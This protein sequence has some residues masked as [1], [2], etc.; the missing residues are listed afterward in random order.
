MYLKPQF[1]CYRHNS[2][3][4]PDGIWSATK[5][6]HFIL[7]WNQERYNHTI[8]WDARTTTRHIRS[9]PSTNTCHFIVTAIEEDLNSEDKAHVCFYAALVLDDEDD[10]NE[11]S[12]KHRHI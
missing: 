12:L 9:A 3:P 11:G 8:P 6:K 7:L 10:R 1:A 5:A 2:G 4:K